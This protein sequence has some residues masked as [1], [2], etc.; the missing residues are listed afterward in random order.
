MSGVDARIQE[1]E[2]IAHRRKSEVE[3]LRAE[4]ESTRLATIGRAAAV[5]A[6]WCDCPQASV[7]PCN[8]IAAEIHDAILKLEGADE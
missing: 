4:I 6:K 7:E 3:R 5:A 8:C 1:L 2:S